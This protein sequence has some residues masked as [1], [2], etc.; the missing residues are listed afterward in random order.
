MSA[1][2]P[3]RGEYVLPL[4]MFFG[5]FSWSFVYVSLPAFQF[6]LYRWYFR[7]FIWMRFLWQVAR[8]ELSLVP[9]HPDRAGGL[10]FLSLSVV[11]FAPLLTAHGALGHTRSMYAPQY[12][13]PATAAVRASTRTR[14][15]ARARYPATGSRR[16]KP[17]RRKRARGK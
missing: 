12:A 14:A 17:G 3:L 4:A 11:A 1:F 9:T 15:E 13:E 8:C 10:G 5:S 6:V 7:L 16:G 2:R